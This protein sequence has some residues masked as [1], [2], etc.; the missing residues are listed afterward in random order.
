[1]ASTFLALGVNLLLLFFVD[2][3]R[4][5]PSCGAGK[6]GIKSTRRKDREQKKPFMKED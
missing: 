5:E 3:N 4:L 2:A 1:M 6:G